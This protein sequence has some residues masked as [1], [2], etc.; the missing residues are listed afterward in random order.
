MIALLLSGFSTRR[1]RHGLW[2]VP[3][4]IVLALMAVLAIG[5]EQFAT[6]ENLFN[7]VAQAMPLLI[8]AIGQMFVIIV[9]GLDLSVGSVISFSTAILS[10]DGPAWLLIPAVFV[11]AALV[12]GING[13]AVKPI[14]T[15]V[16]NPN[17]QES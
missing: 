14:N 1:S 3:L 13:L 7:L 12:G 8:A 6:R 15:Q 9:G 5:T 11:L 4:V 10:L 16:N 2:G 17:P